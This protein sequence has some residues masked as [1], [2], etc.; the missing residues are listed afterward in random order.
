MHLRDRRDRDRLTVQIVELIGRSP[1]PGIAQDALNPA[2]LDRL[3]SRSSGRGELGHDRV[4][5]R[6]FKPRHVD[7]ARDPRE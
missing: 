6:A 2:Y 3:A 7:R 4:P 1:T 5:P